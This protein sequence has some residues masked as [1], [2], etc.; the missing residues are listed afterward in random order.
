MIKLL[1]IFMF[2]S[3]V[4]F[5]VESTEIIS[6]FTVQSQNILML[7]SGFIVALI[8]YNLFLFFKQKNALYLYFV[9]Y[10]ASISYWQFNIFHTS[11]LS[12]S[13]FSFSILF[14]I[15]F[16]RKA[17]DLKTLYPRID[18]LV[19]ITI[20]FYSVY[21]IGLFFTNYQNINIINL[22]SISILLFLSILTFFT[23]LRAHKKSSLIL[24][25]AQVLF[26]SLYTLSFLMQ[27]G[28]VP[29]D[30][31][32]EL[33]IKGVCF[34]E[35][36]LFSWAVTSM[37]KSSKGSSTFNSLGIKNDTK[38]QKQFH[39]PSASDIPVELEYVFN[40]TI[41]AVIFFEDDICVE[42]NDVGIEL[43]MFQSKN[44]ALG[45]EISKFLTSDALNQTQEENNSIHEVN[46][47]KNTKE[48][49]PILYKSI[50]SEINGVS[51]KVAFFIDIS[52]LKR[53]EENLKIAKAKAEDATKI[54]S[55]F[56]ANMSHEIRTPMNGIIGMSHLALQTKLD[57]KQKN[58]IQKI[59]DSAKALLGVIND[60]LDYSKMEAGKLVIENIPFDMHELI[61]STLNVV[62]V[63]SEEKNLNIIINY[64]KDSSS[65]F[66][67]DSLRI[68]QILKNLVSN[69]IKF[70]ENGTIEILFEKVS[71]NLFK[72]SIKDSGIGMS[73]EQQ[74]K[75]F[76][77]FV[78]ADDA[79]TRVYGGTGLGLSI[80]KKLVELMDGKIW[81]ESEVNKG[82]TFSFELPLVELD[83]DT[84]SL[85]NS[86]IDPNSINLLSGSKILLVDDN[87]INQEIVLGLLGKSGIEIDVATNGKEAVERFNEGEYELILM[88]IH[89]PIMNGY[90]A[91]QAIREYGSEIPIIA[92]TA[93]AMKEDVDKTLAS[94]MNEHLNKPID[95]NKL[96]EVLLKYI[97]KKRDSYLLDEEIEDMPLPTFQNIDTEVGL[98]HL[99][100]NRPLYIRILQDFYLQYKDFTLE[101]MNAKEIHMQI[102][103]LKGLS[104]NIGA[105]ALHE[106]LL[107]ID[108]S[109]DKKL[110]KLLYLELSLVTEEIATLFEEK[111]DEPKVLKTTTAQHLQELFTRLKKA[112]HE[113]RPKSISPIIEEIEQYELPESRQESYSKVKEL[114]LNYEY[115]EAEKLL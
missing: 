49:F 94:G 23:Y 43:F 112:L 44:E 99:S 19:F 16:I 73:Q 97:S 48:I 66:Y 25:V 82:S 18:S 35:I 45:K 71:T 41:E 6:L 62:K 21:L 83:K 101:D 110:F 1:F 4:L 77:E 70:T 90:E 95:I 91:T 2:S 74:N 42:I 37:Q 29:F 17:T 65:S 24:T 11:Y 98:H 36:L 87:S 55:E 64:D 105:T 102:H 113:N 86:E 88:D 109:Q 7:C 38:V 33:A 56:L 9:F 93:N 3:S 115:E 8:L 92:L 27:S 32:I 67:G 54:K 61:E 39:S 114:S 10:I 22:V 80:S 111:K 79:T 5:A 53:R 51:T 72:F 15:L 57:S 85:K 76:E 28:E 52:T 84:I 78:Q 107:R 46:A 20:V 81:V 75:L 34:I 104:A 12:S 106:L 63:K 103:T 100:D 31:Q 68:D 50:Y 13:I 30:E 14:L 89:M 59:D 96:Y 47:I 60:I 58:F 26:F 108:E 69:A 40:A